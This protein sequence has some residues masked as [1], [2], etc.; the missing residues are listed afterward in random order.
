[1]AFKAHGE[2]I[3]NCNDVEIIEYLTDFLNDI[4][5]LLL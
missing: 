5:Q 3:A 4:L 1:M 2:P